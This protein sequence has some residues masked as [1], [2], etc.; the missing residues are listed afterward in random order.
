VTLAIKHPYAFGCAENEIDTDRPL[1]CDVGRIG[2]LPAEDSL[3]NHTTDVFG[4]KAYLF[5]PSQTVYSMEPS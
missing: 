5:K 3:P 4:Y 1:F 2:T